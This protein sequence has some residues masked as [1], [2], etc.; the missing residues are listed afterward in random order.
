MSPKSFRSSLRLTLLT[1]LLLPGL[2]APNQAF[3]ARKHAKAKAAPAQ[4]AVAHV[5]TPYIAIDVESGRVIAQRDSTRAWFPASVTKLM[6]VYVALDAVKSGRLTLDT[7]LFVSARAARMQPSKMGFAPGAQV[8]LGN[9]LKMLMVKSANDLAV[10]IAEGVSGSVEAFADEMNA[11]AHA[12]GM[13]ESHFVNPNGLHDPNHYSSARDMA[14]LGRAILLRFPERADLFNIG[15]F[16]LGDQIVPTHNGL[17]GRYPGADGM[18][19]GFTC[20]AGFNLVASATRSGRRVIV[21]VF[22]DTSA[23][24]RTAHA[25]DLLNQSFAGSASNT[26]IADLPSAGGAPPNMKAVACGGRSKQ[27]Q[28]AAESEDFAAPVAAA[29]GEQA[30]PASGAAIAALPRPSYEPVDLFVG[31]APGYQGPVAGPRPADTPIGVIA[32]S[33]PPA[34]AAASAISHHAAT[35]APKPV[36]AHK[37][38]K[39][40]AAAIKGAATKK[41]DKAKAGADQPK[42]DKAAA[43]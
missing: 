3:A 35:P 18:K 31:P 9:A 36:H 13:Q 40:K 17:L 8:T 37:A 33:A 19:T 25:V 7:P 34:A 28:L 32:Y 27:A 24:V 11:S 12:L 10:T 15:A 39:H 38:A 2:A 4:A 6:T 5:P 1:A 42:H 30:A 41:D 14:I 16:R 22:G 26:T 20:P 21:V 43:H 29:E 23:R